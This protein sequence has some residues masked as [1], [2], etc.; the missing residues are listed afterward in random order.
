MTTMQKVLRTLCLGVVAAFSVAS[1]A[2]TNVTDKLLNPDMEK[3]LFGWD[4]TFQ[5]DIWK[6]G[7][8]SQ[9]STPGYHGVN[10]S[11]V[12]VWRYNNGPMT[13]NT[14]SQTVKN[15]PNGTYVFG[16]YMLAN[17]DE[18][19]NIRETIEGVNMFANGDSVP[20]ATNRVEGMDTVWAHTAKFTVATKVT[21]G[22]LKVGVDVKE[23]NVNFTVMDN[24]T[25]YY[26]GD[27]EPAAALD[28]MAKIDIAATIAIADTCLA[29]KMNAETL[30]YLNSVIEAGKAMTSAADAYTTDENLYWGIRQAVKSIKAYSKLG[31]SLDYAEYIA[32][33]TWSEDIDE[34]VAA[35]EAMNALLAEFKEKYE[36][37]TVL[38]EEATVWA[39][40]LKEAAALVELDSCYI[41]AEEYYYAIDE[42]PLGDE[43]GEYTYANQEKALFYYDEIMTIL[44]AAGSGESSAITAMSECKTL[45]GK[46]QQIIDNPIDYSEF[47]IFIG[48]ADKALPNQTCQ[49]G[50]PWPVLEGAYETNEYATADGKYKHL[51]EYKSPLYRFR[52]PL[53][54]VRFY[55]REVGCP[56]EIDT[57][58]NPHICISGF[59]MFDEEGEPIELTTEN[60]ISNATENEGQKIPGMLDYQPNTFF[61][62]L[63]KTGTPEAHYIEVT[64]PEGE[65]S[66]FSFKMLSFENSRSRVFP[67]QLEITYVSEKVTELQQL[68]VS[69]RTKY[70]PVFGTA[71]GFN[72]YDLSPYFN[73]LAE[74]DVVATKNGASDAEAQVAIDKLNAAIAAMEEKGVVLPE[75]GKKYRIIS[76]EP[77]FVKNQYVHKAWTINEEDTTYHNWLW[78]E[79]AGVD[80]VKQEFSFE[81]IGKE[82]NK[83]YYN[84]KHE[85][86]GLYLADWRDADGIRC[87]DMAR[88]TLSEKA[89]SFEVRHIGA[90]EWIFVREGYSSTI[91][92]MLNHNSGVAQPDVAAQSGVGKGKGI[93]SSIIIWNN[94]AYDFSGFYIREMMELPCATKSFSDLN[95]S[96]QTY[97]IYDGINTMTLTADK[98]SAFEGLTFTDG[99]GKNIAP[100]SVTIDGNVATVTFAD[101]IGEFQF[102]FDNAEGVEEVVV[103]GSCAVSANLPALQ[104]TYNQV[105]AIAPVEGV[106]VGQV[107]DLSEYNDALMNAEYLLENGGEEEAILAAKA[108]LDSAK[109]HI[110]Y[111]M[112]KEGVEYFILLGFDAFRTNFLTDMAVRSNANARLL[113]A[114]VGFSDPLCRWEFIDCG[115]LVNDLPAYYIKNVGMGGYATRTLD[116]SYMF[117]ANEAAEARP[118]NLFFIANGKVAL[119]DTNWANGGQSIHPK[120]HS[121]GA[122]MYGDIITWGRTDAASAMRVVEAEAYITDFVYEVTDIEE[123]EAADEQVAPA[124]KGIYDLFGRRIEVPA[125]TG[126][127]IVDGKKQVIK[128]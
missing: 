94:A 43:I 76:S 92:H 11:I 122:G 53:T 118:F 87:T 115:E 56:T 73:A 125:T 99:W 33:Q 23:T 18:R 64:L 111:N 32:A 31:A 78:W 51:I 47:P 86:T 59:A 1:F 96:S 60:V 107:S 100:E 102:T 124:V 101:V 108:A 121:S 109:A 74:G 49:R 3:G 85:A 119:G 77:V 112:P 14:I 62:S 123:I 103:D 48:K 2:Q 5:S 58:G 34:T 6:K 66:A 128:K 52:E 44:A 9:S 40:S 98:E 95:F 50:G 45:F 57:K 113:W 28:E 72:N 25:L 16:A 127:Y 24:A 37:G 70:N 106:H 17:N 91:L 20:V 61:H 29:H 89:D 4:V 46:I 120:G 54:K 88:F 93:R 21:D 82:E 90:G 75:A 110:V 65:Y 69:A 7:S 71:P 19:A 67:S 41:I 97:T 22:T 35:L 63:W 39:D 116:N 105:L 12:E 104:T 10:N 68:L 13:N 38:N 42:L 15:L 126:I 80:S 79:N 55:V 114:Y 26:F 117:L 8:K 84:I 27:M 81:L 83:L 36:A 30:D